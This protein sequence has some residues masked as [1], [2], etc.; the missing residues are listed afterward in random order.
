MAFERELVRFGLAYTAQGQASRLRSFEKSAQ[1]FGNWLVRDALPYWSTF[2]FDWQ[3][4]QFHERLDFSGRPLTE[5]PYR[6]MVQARQVFV[7]AHAAALGWYAEGASLAELALATMIK[8]YRGDTISR[9]GFAFSTT[10]GGALVDARR[11]AYTHAFVMFALA[12]VYRLNGDRKLLA[13][14]E[15]TV[16]FVESALHDRRHRGVFDEAGPRRRLQA[17]KPAHASA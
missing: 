17:A 13:L 2:G 15:E 11:D 14:A 3:N 16:A 4:R 7:F 12:A 6:L 9:S 1:S 5:A 8:R 10:R